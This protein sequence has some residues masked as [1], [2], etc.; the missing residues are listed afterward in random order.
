MNLVDYNNFQLIKRDFRELRKNLFE[1]DNYP[2]SFLA[3]CLTSL[4]LPQIQLYDY[5]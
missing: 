4:E 5:R 3:W 1:E 2:A